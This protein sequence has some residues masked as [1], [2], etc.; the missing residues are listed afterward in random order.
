MLL[1]DQNRLRL[2]LNWLW[3]LGLLIRLLLLGWLSRDRSSSWSFHLLLDN[4][5]LFGLGLLN[6]SW[7][8]L[9]SSLLLHQVLGWSSWG[10]FLLDDLILSLSG[11]LGRLLLVLT[12]PSIG[13]RGR[14]VP[15]G[16][17]TCHLPVEEEHHRETVKG[18][19]NEE[20]GEDRLLLGDHEQKLSGVVSW[21]LIGRLSGWHDVNNC[22]REWFNMD[23]Q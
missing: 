9:S 17:V 4:L 23:R 5:D 16:L 3:S 19:A 10:W 18:K 13:L 15:N 2:L 22:L 21:R 6:R 20:G 7:F 12:N 11:L 8:R 1:L 14:R